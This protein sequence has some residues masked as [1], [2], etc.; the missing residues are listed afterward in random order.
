[1]IKSEMLVLYYD[2]AA[3]DESFFT[4][5][6]EA[7][8]SYNLAKTKQYYKL[9]TDFVFQPFFKV[10]KYLCV[11]VSPNDKQRFITFFDV[12]KDTETLTQLL[13]SCSPRDKMFMNAAIDDVKQSYEEDYYKV[14]LTKGR[15]NT[16]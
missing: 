6:D 3:P 7:S 16:V 2:H 5:T 10:G 8:M 13:Q 1:M 12:K 9:P 4:T 15:P 11:I 14:A